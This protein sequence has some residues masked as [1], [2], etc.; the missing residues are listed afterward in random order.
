MWTS[1]TMSIGEALVVSAMGI[2]IVFAL[3]VILAVSLIIFAKVF[4]VASGT[5]QPEAAGVAPAFD[6]G[7][8]ARI[9]A[10]VCEEMKADPKDIVIKSIKKID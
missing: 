8:Y 2:T 4:N 9:I 10:V 7:V 6:A 3:L 5:K 1:T